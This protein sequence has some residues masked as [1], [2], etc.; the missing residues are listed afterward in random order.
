MARSRNLI[1][2]EATQRSNVNA[3]N[4]FSIILKEMLLCNSNGI[5][6]FI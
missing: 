5:I 6:I 2:I 3:S 1:S 4:I